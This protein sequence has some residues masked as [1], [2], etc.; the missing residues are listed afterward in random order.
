ML[1]TDVAL[2]S[3]GGENAQEIERIQLVY[4]EIAWTWVA[5][6]ESAED[7]WASSA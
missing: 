4:Q 2:I 6:G 7:D 3:S 5:S 1:V